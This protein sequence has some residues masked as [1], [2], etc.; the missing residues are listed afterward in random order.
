MTSLTAIGVVLRGL[1]GDRLHQNY[2]GAKAGQTVQWE[3]INQ[4]HA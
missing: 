1:W 4:M 2:L 3:T